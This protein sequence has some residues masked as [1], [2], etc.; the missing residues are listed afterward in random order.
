M[1]QDYRGLMAQHGCAACAHRV[2]SWCMHPKAENG[3]MLAGDVKH[4]V[5]NSCESGLPTV[6]PD[7]CPYPSTEWVLESETEKH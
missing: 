2:A 3:S 4:Y 6:K 1:L 7:W 5:E